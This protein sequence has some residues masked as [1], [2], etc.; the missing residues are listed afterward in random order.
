MDHWGE[1]TVRV[2][3]WTIRAEAWGVGPDGILVVSGGDLPHIGAIGWQNGDATDGSLEFP[4]HKEKLVVDLFRTV[5]GPESPFR[6]ITAGIHIDRPGPGDLDAIVG[7][8]ETLAA[9][10]RDADNALMRSTRAE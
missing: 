2:K 5:L 6:V 7:A 4:H 3:T 1:W 8:C 9:Q 10:V